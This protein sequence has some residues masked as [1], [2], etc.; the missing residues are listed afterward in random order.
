[1]GYSKSVIGVSLIDKSPWG[2]YRMSNAKISRE[3]GDVEKA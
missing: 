3:D 1:M 2:K